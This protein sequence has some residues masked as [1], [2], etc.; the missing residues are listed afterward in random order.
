MKDGRSLE[1]DPILGVEAFPGIAPPAIALG[2]RP[3]ESADTAQPL[4]LADV[5]SFQVT[6]SSTP[7]LAAQEEAAAEHGKRRS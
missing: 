7:M 2:T 1:V 6:M 4:T 5:R 3:I